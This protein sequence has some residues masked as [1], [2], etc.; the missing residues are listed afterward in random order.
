MSINKCIKCKRT[1]DDTLTFDNNRQ[2][3]LRLVKSRYGH[4]CQRCARNAY[5]RA[6]TRSKRTLRQEQKRKEQE[7]SGQLKM[8]GDME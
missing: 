2:E 5:S 1:E 6:M 4:L 8:F 7:E 3:R